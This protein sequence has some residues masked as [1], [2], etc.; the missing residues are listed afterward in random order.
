MSFTYPIIFWGFFHL[1]TH[2]VDVRR[3][4]R[5][6]G[7]MMTMTAVNGIYAGSCLLGGE[8]EGYF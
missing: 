2:S 4:E 7:R 3:G 6:K 1:D 8:E 5:L